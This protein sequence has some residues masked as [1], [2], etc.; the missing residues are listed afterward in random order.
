MEQQRNGV[1][2]RVVAGLWLAAALSAS[3]ALPREAPAN[4]RSFTLDNGLR[5]I[6][7]ERRTLPLVNI[8]A[9]VGAGAKDETESVS[10]LT[11]LLEHCILFRGTE[12]RT[13]N[14][15]AADMRRHGAYFNAHTGQDL[16]VFELSVPAEHAAFALRIQKEI[17]YG[18]KISDLELES[19]KAVILEEIRQIEDDPL[20]IGSALVYQKLFPGHPYGH[21]VY[22]RPESLK[23]LTAADV[24]A[25]HKRLFVP[26]NTALAVVG[27][28][29][30]DEMEALVRSV[31]GSLPRTDFAPPALPAPAP[32][33]KTVEIELERDVEEGYL[34]IGAAGP[35]YN[36]PDRFAAD[37]LTE[38]LGRGLSPKLLQALR[39]GRRDLVS[40]ASMSCLALRRAGAFLVYAW[41]DP[42]D[43]E[44]AERETLAYLRRV[45]EESFSRDEFQGEAQTYAYE[46]LE[47]AR[48]E[49]RYAVQKAWESGL[50][51]A[52]SLATHVLLD[53]ADAPIDYLERIAKVTSSDL[54]RIGA[55]YLSRA[56]YVV[57]SIKPRP[58]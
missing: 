56:E 45:R 10:G 26:A 32:L 1:R 49:L 2:R 17:L 51:L 46:H 7:L 18:F 19:E 15:V 37:V 23:R 11:H 55:R 40:S 48:N 52:R 41:L 20:R 22:G 14:E 33:A 8:A 54:R 6:L 25:F 29:D 30:L 3:A 43:M 57:V 21:P 28:F 9:A 13:G 58:K 53:E 24:D 38:A 42:K 27:D 34:V 39:G 16:A 5:V 36:S 31:F 4:D 35:G 50:G 47:G 44:A 12:V